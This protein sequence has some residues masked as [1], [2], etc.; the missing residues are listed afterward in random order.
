MRDL[1]SFRE[2]RVREPL[3]GYVYVQ[4]ESSEESG[5]GGV[6]TPL[7]ARIIEALGEVQ[8]ASETL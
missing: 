1:A 2:E 4:T 6:R 3:V 8:I 7:G 5:D